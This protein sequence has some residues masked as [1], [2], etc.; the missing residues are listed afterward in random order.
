MLKK[1]AAN[2]GGTYF[3]VTDTKGLY[4][5]YNTIDKLEKNKTQIIKQI[6]YQY[7][8]GVYA[9]IALMLLLFEIVLRYTLLRTWP[10]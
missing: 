8:F 4:N 7:Q 1:I 6:K 9:S 5:T 3:N 2:T 10:Q